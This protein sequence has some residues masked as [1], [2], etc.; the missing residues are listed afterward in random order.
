MGP[1]R[2]HVD[3]HAAG[4]ESDATACSVDGGFAVIAEHRAHG[5]R[6]VALSTLYPSRMAAWMLER[7]S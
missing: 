7:R 4:Q 3:L 5:G 1:M 2:T 6:A